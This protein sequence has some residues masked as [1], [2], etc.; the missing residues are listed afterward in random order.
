MT[1]HLHSSTLEGQGCLHGPHVQLPAAR[2]PWRSTARHAVP[3]RCADFQSPASG[4]PSRR[5]GISSPSLTRRR[6]LSKRLLQPVPDRDVS[7][8]AE[9]LFDYWCAA[10]SHY[11][12]M[13]QTGRMVSSHR[14][15]L[16]QRV[17]RCQDGG[18]PCPGELSACVQ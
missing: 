5:S 12:C 1:L 9:L 8:Q 17:L 4:V 14:L 7:Q 10:A 18:D 3:P 2:S 13:C 15:T 11:H 16:P 6:P